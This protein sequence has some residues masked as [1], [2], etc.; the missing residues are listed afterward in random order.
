VTGLNEV[1]VR[2]YRDEDALSVNELLTVSL[3]NGPAGER[4]AEFFRWKHLSNPFGRSFMLVAEADGRI[5]GFRA[6]MRWRFRARSG[7]INAVRAVDTATHPDHQ[8]RGIFSL[9]TEEALRALRGE[10]DL[11][12]NTPNEKSLPGYLKLG[13]HLIE[14]I[15]PS[16][17]VRKPL[18]VARGV[19]TLRVLEAGSRSWERPVD[20]E[21]AASVLRDDQALSLIAAAAQEEDRFHTPRD[22]AFLRWRYGAAPHLDYWAV[23][24]ERAGSLQGLALFRVRPRGILWETA[25]L[26]VLVPRGDVRTASRLLR[27]VIL[28]ADVDHVGCRFPTASTVARAARRHGFV[29]APATAPFVVNPLR[30][31]LRPDPAIATSWALTLGD[32]EV[33]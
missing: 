31:G 16:V 29:P 30:G 2:P 6:L 33:F 23:R 14:Q 13:W 11:V 7:A 17:R 20:G 24:V 18:R 21:P 4:S 27:K 1:T 26:D 5:V 15:R 19:R 3:G 9:L 25:V 12:F 32:L 8:R 22:V 28:A 10:V